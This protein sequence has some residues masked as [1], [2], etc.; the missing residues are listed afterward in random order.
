MRAV[1][2]GRSWPQDCPEKAYGR[3]NWRTAPAEAETYVAAIERHLLRWRA[4]EEIDAQTGVS[5]LASIMASCAILRDAQEF[6][7][8]IDNRR[9]T[10]GVLDVMDRYDASSMTVVKAA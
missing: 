9:G 3:W 5:H 1:P 4:G 6:G 2:R 10:P 8:L 7:T